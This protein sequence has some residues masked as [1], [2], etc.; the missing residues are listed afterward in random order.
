MLRKIK[1]FV[2]NILK[3]VFNSFENLMDKFLI[4]K[5]KKGEINKFKDKRRVEI[6]SKIKLTQEQEKSIDKLYKTAYGRRIPYIWHRHFMA[7]TGK[8]DEKY[9]PELLYIPEFEHYM[10]E[11]KNFAK[12]VSDKNMLSFIAKGIGI[13]MPKTVLSVSDGI[14]KNDKNEHV[15]REEA[16]KYLFNI[17]KVFIKPTVDSCSGM[18]CSVLNIQ[19]GI[20]IMG[21]KF[22]GYNTGSW[23]KFC[24]SRMCRMPSV[25]K[26]Y[27]SKQCKYISCYD[28]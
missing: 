23:K 16:E 26:S 27:L 11:D 12:V 5:L 21:G 22:V 1:L 17:G 7:Y 2:K 14:F 8:F 6:Y 28:L 19:N 20:D 4:Y 3:I 13:S 15:S 10:N 9:F 18:G 24:Y 25:N